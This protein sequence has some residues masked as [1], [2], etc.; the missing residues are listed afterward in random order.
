MNAE[1]TYGF[2]EILESSVV[3]A[4]AS[5]KTW[6]GVLDAYDDSQKAASK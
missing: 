2:S 6:E 3:P 1:Q 4:L 5:C